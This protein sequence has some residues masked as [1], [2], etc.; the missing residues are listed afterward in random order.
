MPGRGKSPTSRPSRSTVTRLRDVE[1]LRQAMADE[2]DGDAVSRERPHHVEQ[3]IRLGLGKR[4][5][6]LVHEH[7]ARV[8]NQRAGDRRRSDAVRLAECADAHR[9]RGA[10]RACRARPLPIAHRRMVHEPGRAPT[11]VSKAM[12][13]ATVI[14]GN[15]AR[16]CQITCDPAVA[17]RI[18]RHGRLGLAEIVHLGAGLRPIDAAMIL[19]SVLLPLPF[20]PARQ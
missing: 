1:H 2:H 12:F 19:I 18:G 5:R 7:E 15:S 4:R 20:S 13:S 17:R 6:R 3:S 8:A 16:S 9:G 10:R 11:S 14:S